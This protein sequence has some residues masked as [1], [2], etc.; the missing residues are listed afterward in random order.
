MSDGRKMDAWDLILEI[1][2]ESKNGYVGG[3]RLQA[4]LSEIAKVSA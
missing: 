3:R 1:G 4:T 2:R